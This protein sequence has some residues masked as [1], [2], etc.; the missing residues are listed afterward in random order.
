MV[1]TGSQVVD[2]FSCQNA[3]PERNFSAQMVT[4]RHLK[5]LDFLIWDDGVLAFTE[6]GCDFPV[7]ITYTLI[8]PFDLL[9]DPV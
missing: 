8:G 9:Y 7:Q 4:T 3:K 1:E 6:K 2:D 5:R